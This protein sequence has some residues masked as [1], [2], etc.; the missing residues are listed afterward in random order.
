VLERLDIGLYADA[1]FASL[2]ILLPL[3]VPEPRLVCA[4]PT[5]LKLPLIVPLLNWT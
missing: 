1:T 3:S 5:K 2:A 4:V